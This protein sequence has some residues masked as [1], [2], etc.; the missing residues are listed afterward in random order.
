MLLYLLFSVFL[1][2]FF[3][4]FLVESLHN[5]AIL[6]SEHLLQGLLGVHFLCAILQFIQAFLTCSLL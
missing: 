4:G 2:F 5:S 1:L 3:L 6:N